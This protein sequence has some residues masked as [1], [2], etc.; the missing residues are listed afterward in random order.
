VTESLAYYTMGAFD[1]DGADAMSYDNC[2]C[3][4][5]GPP[6]PKK[7]SCSS[8]TL[9]LQLRVSLFLRLHYHILMANAEGARY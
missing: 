9:S 7:L 4:Y 1:L 8:E 5:P 3:C 2:V 6:R